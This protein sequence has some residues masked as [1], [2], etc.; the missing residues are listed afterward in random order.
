M[1]SLPSEF[2]TKDDQDMKHDFTSVV[3]RNATSLF[4]TELLR[5]I[6]E[7]KYNFSSPYSIP[8]SSLVTYSLPAFL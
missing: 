3:D 5:G 6:K 2:V 8:W 7:K 1:F 4:L